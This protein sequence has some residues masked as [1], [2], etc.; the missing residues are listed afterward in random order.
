MITIG[1]LLKKRA[2]DVINKPMEHFIP[3]LPN[4]SPRPLRQHFTA[5]SFGRFERTNDRIKQIQLVA[6]GFAEAVCRAKEPGGPTL[7]RDNPLLKLIGVS[8]DNEEVSSLQRTMNERAKKIVNLRPL[9]YQ[10]DRCKLHYEIA[11]SSVVLMLSWH[12]GFGL[13]V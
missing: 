13:R 7:L 5:V 9:P 1:P 3:G 2:T 10:E 4:I 11:G 6:E 12:E 8:G